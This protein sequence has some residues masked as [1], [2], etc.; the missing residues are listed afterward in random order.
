MNNSS[1][2]YAV[3]QV[4]FPVGPHTGSATGGRISK[5]DKN[6][7]V[8]TVVDNLPSSHSTATDD[9][10]MQQVTAKK[11]SDDSDIASVSVTISEGRAVLTGTVNSSAAKAKA[12]KFVREVR[13]VRSIDNKIVVSVQ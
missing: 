4:P 13:G 1:I 7:N 5:V 3:D 6:G 2:T 8:T 9:E 11:V 10:T 12:E